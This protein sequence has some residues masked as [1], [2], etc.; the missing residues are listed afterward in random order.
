MMLLSRPIKSVIQLLRAVLNC[1]PIDS[2]TLLQLYSQYFPICRI[3]T[4]GPQLLIP[5][6]DQHHCFG[7]GIFGSSQPVI[8]SPMILIHQ[9]TIKRQSSPA[10][11]FSVRLKWECASKFVFLLKHLNGEG[12]SGRCISLT[13]ALLC[14]CPSS[15]SY[16]KHPPWVMP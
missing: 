8:S 1:F 2:R 15:H 10:E 6:K 3:S 5:E 12:T 7:L 16:H 9:Q 14:W 13:A 4:V 11:S